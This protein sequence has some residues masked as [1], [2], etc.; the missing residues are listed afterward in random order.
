[1][2]NHLLSIYIKPIVIEYLFYIYMY[3]YLYTIEH[4]YS[5]LEI[6]HHFEDTITVRLLDQPA[7]YY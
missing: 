1:M 2:A 4:E 5:I 7:S 6:K 3:I